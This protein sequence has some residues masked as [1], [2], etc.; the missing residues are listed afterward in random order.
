LRASYIQQHGEDP[1]KLSTQFLVDCINIETCSDGVNGCCGGNPYAA[2]EYIMQHGGIPTQAD[3]GDVVT[4]ASLL[5]VD[6]RT[7]AT[8]GPISNTHGLTF[9]GNHP[10]TVFPCKAGI[11]N[12]VTL[13]ALPEKVESETDIA[14]YVCNTGAVGIV[15]DASKWNSYKG[16]VLTASSCAADTDHA[17][18]LVGMSASENAYIVQNQWGKDWGVALD[19]T[20]PPASK[21]SNCPELAQGNG[22]TDPYNAWIAT[23]CALECSGKVVDGGYVFLKFG[24]NTCG[25]TD[26][27]LT[28]L[29]TATATGVTQGLGTTTTTTTA[30]DAWLA[31]YKAGYDDGKDGKATTTTKAPPSDQDYAWGFNAGYQDG[32]AG[33]PYLGR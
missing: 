7:N 29:Q 17:V 22:C 8:G 13:T 2:F 11:K 5:Q 18:T 4:P 9:S 16:G 31:G 14:N 33:N 25:I 3:Y 19:G 6:A 24:E 15:V 26:Q 12:S 10:K 20:P 21:W 1:G 23:D 32:Q 28:P 30:Y 27:A